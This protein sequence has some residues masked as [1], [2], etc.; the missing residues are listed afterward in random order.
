ME[1]HLPLKIFLDFNRMDNDLYEKKIQ[2]QET[3]VL[4]AYTQISTM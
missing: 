4:M 1:E 2:K 3:E